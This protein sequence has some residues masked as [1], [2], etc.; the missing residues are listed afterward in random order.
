MGEYLRWFLSQSHAEF[1]RLQ[2]PRDSFVELYHKE[3][4]EAE[5]ADN[6]AENSLSPNF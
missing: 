6:A 2:G 4:K 1:L 5:T 3:E